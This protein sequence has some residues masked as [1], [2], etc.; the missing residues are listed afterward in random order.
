M[1]GA[2]AGGIPHDR[3][4]IV[5]GGDDPRTVGGVGGGEDLVGVSVEPMPHVAGGGVHQQRWVVVGRQQ[6]RGAVGGERHLVALALRG[7]VSLSHDGQW[8]AARGVPDGE[9][10]DEAA[11]IGGPR[12]ILAH[13]RSLQT[14]QQRSV[15]RVEDAD[16]VGGHDG[17]L[18]VV[19]RQGGPGE[20]AA[21]QGER[22]H[23][24]ARGHVPPQSSAIGAEREESSAALRQLGAV[25][26]SDVTE[27]R[28]QGRGSSHSRRTRWLRIRRRLRASPPHHHPDQRPANH[29]TSPAASLPPGRT[30]IVDIPVTLC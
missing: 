9:V 2:P 27:L 17:H 24:Q 20:A 10:R 1:Q 29:R 21:V 11:T 3:L 6:G 8:L 7:S 13:V 15:L 25:D 22:S 18:A 30:H 19:G 5:G 4:A 26:R 16:E 28:H 12:D 14:R 23:P